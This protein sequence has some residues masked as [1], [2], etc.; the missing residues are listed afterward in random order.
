MTVV[1]FCFGAVQDCHILHKASEKRKFENSMSS[2]AL[3]LVHNGDEEAD[4]FEDG[5]IEHKGR[6]YYQND[7]K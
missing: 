6:Y 3:D 4:V 2:Q 7:D 1:C 5:V